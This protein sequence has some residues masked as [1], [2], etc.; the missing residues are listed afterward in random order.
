MYGWEGST[1]NAA[2]CGTRL[3]K[4]LA[5]APAGASSKPMRASA[6]RTTGLI[7]AGADSD[8]ALVPLPDC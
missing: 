4:A 7:V 1:V 8:P 2:C 5:G 6:I 3:K